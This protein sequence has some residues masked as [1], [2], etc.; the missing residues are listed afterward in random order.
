MS[1]THTTQAPADAS[2]Q[3]LPPQLARRGLVAVFGSTFLELVGVFMLSPL[4]LLTLKANGETTLLAGLFAACGW[5]GIFFV[6]PWV[7]DITRRLGRRRA[8]WLAAALPLLATSGFLLTDHLAVWFVLE[9]L[10]G[11]A[12]GLRWVLAE[13]VVAECSPPGRRGRYVGLFE[14]MVGATFVVGPALLAWVGTQRGVALWV[15]LALTGAG[16]LWSLWIPALPLADAH[17][18]PSGRRGL[19]QALRAH[20]VVMAAGLVGGFFES[21][22]SSLLPLY[23]LALELPP[24]TSALLVSASGLGSA[25]LMLPAGVLADRMAHHPT[26]RWGNQGQARQT[27]MRAFAWLTLVATTVVPWVAPY[28][29]LAWGVVFLWGGAGGCLY[30]LAMIDIGD[31]ERGLALVNGTAVLVMSYTLGGVLAP[32]LGAWALEASPSVAFPTLML[33]VAV[34]GV[35]AVRRSDK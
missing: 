27:L 31:R 34:A 28:P 2:A 35:W 4:L 25:V 11:M 9:F 24:A 18:A 20:P 5:V 26:G 19:W 13:A 1:R 14:T 33:G 16:L 22:V 32:A 23:G 7:A 8:L 12:G 21:G 17:S 10:A 6:T 3:A 15:V 29:A 30:T